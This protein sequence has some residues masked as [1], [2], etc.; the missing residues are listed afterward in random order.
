MS[1]SSRATALTTRRNAIAIIKNI[2]KTRRVMAK[3]PFNEKTFDA[4][5]GQDRGLE[6]LLGRE[7]IFLAL[8]PAEQLSLRHEVNAK[9]NEVEFETFKTLRAATLDYF[10]DLQGAI[11]RVNMEILSKTSADLKSSKKA[12][13]EAFN[14]FAMNPGA[15]DCER[16]IST[17]EHLLAIAEGIDES[18]P[19]IEHDLDKEEYTEEQHQDDEADELPDLDDDDDE[20]EDLSAPVELPNTEPDQT[21]DDPEAVMPWIVTEES[22]SNAVQRFINKE[23]TSLEKL[24]YTTDRCEEILTRYTGA[25]ETYV[26]ALTKFRDIIAPETC[27]LEDLLRGSTKFFQNYDRVIDLV[28]KFEPLRTALNDSCEGLI[29]ASKVVLEKQVIDPKL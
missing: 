4:I 19:D 5:N 6:D 25:L 22:F 1:K 3:F 2:R 20:G 13:V 27:T 10:K 28:E 21:E 11:D 8:S 12:A 16:A 18:T 26:K 17:I 29:V 24:G 9:L 7:V 14:N 23:E 15:L